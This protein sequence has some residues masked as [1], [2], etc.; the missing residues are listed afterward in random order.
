MYVTQDSLPTSCLLHAVQ[1]NFLKLYTTLMNSLVPRSTPA[2]AN[3]VFWS[4]TD[5]N[6]LSL[7]FTYGVKFSKLPNL[8]KQIVQPAFLYFFFELLLLSYRPT[9]RLS[10]I[11][12]KYLIWSI[13]E[14]RQI[15]IKLESTQKQI[16]CLQFAVSL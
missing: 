9:K 6:F 5:D 7:G 3:F 13:T 15:R 14:N 10:V 8:I 12:S 1:I 4:T 11:F 2:I 16:Y